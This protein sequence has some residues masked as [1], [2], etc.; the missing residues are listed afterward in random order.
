MNTHKSLGLLA[1]VLVTVVQTAIF[2]TDTSSVAGNVTE[3]SEYGQSLG[4]K[5]ALEARAVYGTSSPSVIG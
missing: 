1:A 5:A 2:A 4:G 3:R